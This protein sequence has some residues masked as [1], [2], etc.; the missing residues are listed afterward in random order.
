MDQQPSQS[1]QHQAPL[2]IIR[3]D[4][5]QMAQILGDMGVTIPSGTIT[6]KDLNKPTVIFLIKI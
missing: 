5:N 6:I 4:L 2:A 1:Q 3:Y